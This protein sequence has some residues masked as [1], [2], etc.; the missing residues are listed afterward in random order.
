MIHSTEGM[1]AP[2]SAGEKP[3]LDEHQAQIER[4]VS[5]LACTKID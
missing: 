1:R 5:I 4:A 3:K 2:I